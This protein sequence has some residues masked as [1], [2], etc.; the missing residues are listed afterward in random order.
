MEE[1]KK[2][3]RKGRSVSKRS[4]VRSQRATLAEAFEQYCSVVNDADL[5]EDAPER[6]EAVRK[7]DEA[8]HAKRVYYEATR[9]LK[10]L[11]GEHADATGDRE[12]VLLV[13]RTIK[14]G[15]RHC[16]S[17]LRALADSRTFEEREAIRREEIRVAD[18]RHAQR[19]G[20]QRE[21]AANRVARIKRDEEKAEYENRQKDERERQLAED[22][23][24]LAESGRQE[25]RHA[26]DKKRKPCS[27]AG[28]QNRT[29]KDETAAIPSPEL[30]HEITKILNEDFPSLTGPTA[31]QFYHKYV[32]SC[33]SMAGMAES[34]AKV[35]GWSRRTLTSRR[36]KI[37][38]HLSMRFGLLVKLNDLRT[39][40][41]KSGRIIPTDPSII[42]RTYPDTQRDEM[43]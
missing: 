1:M 31:S 42:E 3:M 24:F 39:A 12:Y 6:R 43:D 28:Q 8:M 37:E 18:Q 41:R 22:V 23:H 32:I 17:T 16:L 20:D 9:P 34:Y 25:Q 10:E 38:E 4:K 26:T 11:D 30:E 19:A 13:A 21:Q 40:P 2:K 5:P 29:V 33:R 14:R 7:W 35:K 15:R 36:L 27:K